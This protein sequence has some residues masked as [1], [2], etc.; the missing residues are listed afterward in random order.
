MSDD[1][2]TARLTCQYDARAADGNR[3]FW[4]SVETWLEEFPDAAPFFYWQSGNGCEYRLRPSVAEKLAAAGLPPETDLF[5]GNIP[6]GWKERFQ[7]D[8]DLHDRLYVSN[9]MIC[10]LVDAPDEAAA[11]DLVRAQFPDMRQRFISPA[12]DKTLTSLGHGG[13]FR[14][15]VAED[16]ASAPRP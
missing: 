11:W 3:R 2:R 14:H 4:M 7:E 16:A 15:P 9:A 1:E 13:R 8:E 6:G 12:D 10:M 5:G